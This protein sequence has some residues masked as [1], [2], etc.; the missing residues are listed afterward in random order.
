MTEHFTSEEAVALAKA[1][2]FEV[3]RVLGLRESVPEVVFAHGLINEEV[4]ALCNA[5]VTAI[6]KK[7][8]AQAAVAKAVVLTTGIGLQWIGEALPAGTKLFTHPLAASPQEQK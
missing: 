4:T 3:R 1:A 7:R 5:A 6:D 2:G 8:E